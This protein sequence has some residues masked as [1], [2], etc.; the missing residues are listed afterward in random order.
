MV[1][2]RRKERT[3]LQGGN[4]DESRCAGVDTKIIK[5]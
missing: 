3:E 4:K 1:R 5:H 2:A